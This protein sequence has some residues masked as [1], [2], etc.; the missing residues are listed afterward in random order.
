MQSFAITIR[1]ELKKLSDQKVKTDAERYFKSVIIFHG[2]KTPE[3]NSFYRTLLPEIHSEK[4]ND[5]LELARILLQSKYAEEKGIAIR[6]LQTLRQ[7]LGFEFLESFEPDFQKHV[8][9]WGTADCLSG[10]VFR[11]LIEDGNRKAIGKI[12]SWRNDSSLW[13]QRM[14]AVSFVWL[15]RHGQVTAEVLRVCK[16]TVKNPERFTQ[17][18]T[19]WVLREL[20]LAEPKIVEE[21]ILKHHKYLSREGLRYSIEKM[22]A[23]LR[24]QFLTLSP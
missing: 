15:A 16:S 1:R 3:L 10:K 7:G 19:G 6:I 23:E 14:A 21:F 13:M 24:K 18:G 4:F 12:V 8:Y 11:H 9:D 22:P 2:I 17:L 5:M 20:W